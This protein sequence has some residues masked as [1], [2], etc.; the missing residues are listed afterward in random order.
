MRTLLRDVASA[1]PDRVVTNRQLQTEHPDWNFAMLVEK[2][3]VQERH[4]A[5]DDETALDLGERACR[6]LFARW[7]ALADNL[8]VLIFC[9]QTPDHVLP[10]NS[11]ILHGRLGLAEHVTA[12]DLNHACSGYIYAIAQA[13]AFIL[14]RMAKNVLIVN[15][16]TYSKLIHS[17]DRSA[18]ALF[19]DGAAATWIEAGDESIGIVDVVCRTA[20]AH[21]DKFI[22]P[23]GGCR[24]ARSNTTCLE[25]TD[26]SGNVRTLEHI[27]MSGRD[28]LAFVT[29][30]IPKHVDEVLN[31]NQ[32]SREQ[33]DLYIFH[34]ASAMVLDSLSRLL[35]LPEEKVYRNLSRIGNTVSA[36]IPLAL[37]DARVS[38]QLKS[39]ATVLLCGFGVGLSWGSAVVRF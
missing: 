36:S 16:D 29:S 21:Y 9:T 25:S 4:I 22:V 35:R 33:I 11:C 13:Q 6:D 2:A 14:A 28:I 38:G 5:R 18:R 27:H 7:P 37:A 17:N 20:G 30:K 24:H 34:Q 26:D 23:A 19:G 8:D 39:P 3:G 1:L 10:P 32:L 31:R 15:A 12:F